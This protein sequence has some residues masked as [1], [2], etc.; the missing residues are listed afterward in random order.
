MMAGPAVVLSISSRAPWFT[1][2]TSR[3]V[4]GFDGV[5]NV[6]VSEMILDEPRISALVG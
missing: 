2:T 1:A 3:S 6:A 4:L 5:L